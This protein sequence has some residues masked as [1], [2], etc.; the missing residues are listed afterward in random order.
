MEEVLKEE[1]KPTP[2]VAE[3]QEPGK[4]EIKQVIF[5]CCK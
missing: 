1:T 2:I 3:K 4:E 5:Q